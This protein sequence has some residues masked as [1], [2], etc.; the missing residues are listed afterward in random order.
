[1][2]LLKNGLAALLILLL[3]SCSERRPAEA[4]AQTGPLTRSTAG[5]A[6][7]NMQGLATATFAGGCFWC[8]EE[9]FEELKGVQ[10]VVSGYS[11]GKEANPTYEE[12]GSGQTGHAES[13]EI[14]YDPKQIS[15][16][17]LVDVFF[18]AAHDPTTLNRQ[19]PDAG[20][21]YRSIAFYR[22]PSE[23]KIIEDAIS[24]VNASKQYSSPIVTQ[25]VP[26]QRFWPAE[27]YHQGYFRLH[28]GEGYVQSVSTPKVE[29]FRHKFPQLLRKPL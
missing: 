26:F 22:T 28:P 2:N 10:A 14:Y 3:A 9:I 12:V 27:G 1:M 19:G 23:K 8:T 21:Q 11:G 13:V 29:K 24:R 25:V 16:A 18:R 20:R 7:T 4:Q 5:P 15:F 6:P 17:T